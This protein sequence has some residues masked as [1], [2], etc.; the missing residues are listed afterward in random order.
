MAGARRG[1]SMLEFALVGI[2]TIFLVVSLFEISMIMWQY[3]TLAEVVARVARY[4]AVN[5]QTCYGSGYSC[6]TTVGNIATAI[7]N[8]AVGILPANLTITLT[9][10]G[11]QIAQ[12]TVESFISPTLNATDFPPDNSNGA[13][14]SQITI[15]ASYPIP[16]PLFGYWPGGGTMAEQKYTLKAT[17][18][19]EI[20]F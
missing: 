10:N 16:N 11:S 13:A 15:V 8:Q 1:S 3:H 19:Q 20:L 7:K 9:A 18:T 2:P 5:G 17:S 4:A 6:G 12:G 14:G